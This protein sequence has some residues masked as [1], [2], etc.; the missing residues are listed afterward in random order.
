MDKILDNI[1]EYKNCEADL[2]TA[3]RP[4]GIDSFQK[5]HDEV[6]E[7]GV[8]LPSTMKERIRQAY[9]DLQRQML[10]EK[11]RAVWQ[12]VDKT[13][14]QAVMAFIQSNPW[15]EC[16]NEAKAIL[17]SLRKPE[18]TEN[19]VII[20]NTP[21]VGIYNLAKR[22]K[23]IRTDKSINN[24]EQAIYDC[25]I[26]FIQ[27]GEITVG[28]LLEAIRE[29]NN[30]ISSHTATKLWQDGVVTD[31]GPT[32]IDADFIEYIKDGKTL[33]KFPVLPPVFHMTKNPC[34]EVYFWG[35]P[36]SGKTCALGGVLST[37]YNGNLAYSME[38]DSL[39]QGYGYMM[40]LANL[41]RLKSSVGLLPHGNAVTATYE[42]GFD[43]EDKDGKIHPITCV[44]LAGELIG[45]MYKRN[46]GEQ[47]TNQEEGALTILTDKLI[48][49]RS[50]NTKMHFFVIE[51]GAEDK[52]YNGL[53]QDSLLA[54]TAEY[55]KRTHVFNS[56]T[57]SIY[58]LITKSDKANAKGKE[59][60]EKLRSYM[61]DNY[62]GFYNILRSICQQN[63]INNG[64]VE[65]KPFTIGKVCF[66]N[67]CKFKDEASSDIVKILINRSKGYSRKEWEKLSNVV[68]K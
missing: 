22:I 67:Y 13:D 23:K 29:D 12:G 57:D 27:S 24:P 18:N 14:E 42:M 15:S 11:S 32:C 50:N 59:L 2:V 3:L 53:P 36:S 58:I 51:Y 10:E 21:S 1:Q 4:Y 8:P 60:V 65:I 54:S 6:T 20:N 34:T 68:K 37:A 9:D 43:L 55:I 39:C 40:R 30:F 19:T 56:N 26:E 41:F 16:A 63:K 7:Y 49:N 5:F 62:K 28:D 38:P 35:I 45:A 64:V 61:V 17:D 25:I 46:A 47:L 66:E 44:D 52:L 33:E 31:F 48:K